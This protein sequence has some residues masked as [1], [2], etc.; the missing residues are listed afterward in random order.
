MVN[1]RSPTL[2]GEFLMFVAVSNHMINRTATAMTMSL[3][4]FRKVGNGFSKE[5]IL[6]ASLLMVPMGHKEHQNRDQK[7]AP[8]ISIGHPTAQLKR[9]AGFFI[10]SAGPRNRS[11]RSMKKNGVTAL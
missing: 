10:G 7:N 11:T 2:N 8:R 1:N 4:F 6:L 5:I 3:R 9:A